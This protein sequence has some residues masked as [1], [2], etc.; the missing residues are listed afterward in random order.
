[1]ELLE[2]FI[3]H[4]NI[5]EVEGFIEKNVLNIFR[6]NTNIHLDGRGNLSHIYLL[7]GGWHRNNT[8]EPTIMF[9]KNEVLGFDHPLI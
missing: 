8:F 2:E 4:D 7:E 1:M 6:D 9:N 3:V 5:L